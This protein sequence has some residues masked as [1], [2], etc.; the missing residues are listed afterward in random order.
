MRSVFGISVGAM[1]ACTLFVVGL[2]A[3]VPKKVNGGVLNGKAVSLPKPHYPEAAQL[4]K[5]SGMVAVNVEIDETGDVAS[6]E[7]DPYDQREQFNA[8]GTKADPVLVEQ[9][10][11]DAA[12]EAALQAK[13]SPTLLSGVPVRVTG[14]IVYNFVAVESDKSPDMSAVNGG[15]LNGKA[16]ELPSPAYP[17][18]AKAVRADGT[19]TVRVTIDEGG[20]VIAAEAISGHP[21]LRSAAVEAAKAAKFSATTLSG[22]PVK[23]TGALTYNFVL[24]AQPDE[25]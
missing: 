10:L 12:V 9:S 15:L 13:F 19:V 25:R 14:R 1:L 21:L 20:S 3:Q 11:R 6:A 17:P 18:A 4:A 23:V 24:P 22:Q 7:A 8:D 2:L 16:I 5:A